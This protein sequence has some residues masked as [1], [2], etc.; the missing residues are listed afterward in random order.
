[1]S[2]VPG[3]CS[4]HQAEQVIEWAARW[5]VVGEGEVFNE[6]GSSEHFHMFLPVRALFQVLLESHVSEEE[7]RIS[8]Q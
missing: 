7:L 2:C 5:S 4:S 8:V 3:V 6:G 1:M